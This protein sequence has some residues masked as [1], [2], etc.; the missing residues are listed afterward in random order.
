MDISAVRLDMIAL[1][2]WMEMFVPLPT[3]DDWRT[4]ERIDAA[5]QVE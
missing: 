4:L 5:G 2:C 1:M 3:Y